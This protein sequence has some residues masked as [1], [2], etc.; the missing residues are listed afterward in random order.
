MEWLLS[1]IIAII[2]AIPFWNA[3]SKYKDEEENTWD[4]THDDY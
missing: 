2:I 4:G 3:P 1:F